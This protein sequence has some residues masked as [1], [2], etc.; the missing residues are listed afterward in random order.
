[1]NSIKRYLGRSFRGVRER[2]GTSYCRAP[3]ALATCDGQQ[4]GLLLCNL[5]FAELMACAT[6]EDCIEQFSFAAHLAYCSHNQTILASARALHSLPNQELLVKSTKGRVV[7][8]YCSLKFDPETGNMELAA[9]QLAQEKAGTDPAPDAPPDLQSELEICRQRLQ[10]LLQSTCS[11]CW[12]WDLLKDRI[13]DTGMAIN[14]TV[15]G[16]QRNQQALD[17]CIDG[18][19]DD[20]LQQVKKAM[21]SCLSGEQPAFDIEFRAVNADGAERWIKAYGEV[22]ARG[23]GDEP[24]QLRGIHTDVT[25]SRHMQQHIG[26][27][28]NLLFQARKM[29]A[30]GQLTGG[31]SHDFNNILASVIGFATLLL[32]KGR[33][34]LDPSFKDYLQEICKAGKLGQDMIVRMLRF[35]RNDSADMVPAMISLLIRDAVQ[36]IRPSMPSSIELQLVIDDQ[37]PSVNTNSFKLSQMLMNLCANARDAMGGNGILAIGLEL[38]D[39]SSLSCTACGQAIAGQFVQLSVADSGTGIDEQMLPHIFADF[40]TTK[41]PGEGTGMGLPIVNNLIHEHNGHIQVESTAGKGTRFNLLFPPTRQI[42]PSQPVI[43]L[44]VSRFQPR[45]RGHILVVDDDK[46]VG[47]YLSEVLELH[48]HR[49]TFEPDSRLAVDLLQE[50]PHRFDVIVADQIMPGITGTRLIAAVQRIRKELP[51]IIC[52]GDNRKTSEIS[53]LN[54]G[55]QGYLAKPVNVD[56]LLEL[57]DQ[58]LG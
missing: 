26:D 15:P 45:K 24:L 14:S 11:I 32:E 12:E 33:D 25:E 28:Q 2:Q 4:D 49:V 16:I 44:G 47:R 39:I 42:T 18:I 53:A 37:L 9:M 56:K 27:L 5:A 50:K 23:P 7:P 41:Q 29:H 40:F 54:A 46:S 10:F 6:I 8:V 35:A 57:I 48:G 34:S 52:S 19:N 20:D 55:A 58:S 30:I 13:S 22:S 31:F 43:N 21:Q 36:L 1:M 17:F 51:V 38:R 3:V